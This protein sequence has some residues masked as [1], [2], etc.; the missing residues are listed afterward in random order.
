MRVLERWVSAKAPRCFRSALKFMMFAPMDCVSAPI[1][2]RD[3]FV[4]PSRLIDFGRGEFM[5]VGEEF[6][7]HFVRLAGLE[8]NERALDVGCG[9]GRIAAK[10][11][12][13]LGTDGSYEGFDISKRANDWCI[14]RITTK[15]PNLHFRLIGLYDGYYHPEGTRKASEYALPHEDA[16]FDFVFLASVLTRMLS[17]DM[18]KHFFETGRVL[19]ETGRCLKTFLLLNEGFPGAMASKRS[20]SP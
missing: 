2:E 3:E 10:L 5:R 16:S 20:G 12:R 4:S 19:R 9:F 17:G 1:A 11:I 8:Q 14:E 6:F 7:Q 15:Y 18:E 13:Y